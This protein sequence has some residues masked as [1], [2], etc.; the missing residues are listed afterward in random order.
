MAYSV[1]P[2]VL[3][4]PEVSFS[5]SI[6]HPG[7]HTGTPGKLSMLMTEPLAR[8]LILL[9]WD[10]VLALRFLTS[11]PLPPVLLMCS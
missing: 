5:S 7:L 11:L 6:R 3:W 9:V 10:S 4:L 2:H 8:F 1:M